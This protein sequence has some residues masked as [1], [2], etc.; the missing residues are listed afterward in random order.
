MFR[1]QSVYH[2]VVAEIMKEVI[3]RHSRERHQIPSQDLLQ[4]KR[5]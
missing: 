4:A 2:R 5:I 1:K 3:R